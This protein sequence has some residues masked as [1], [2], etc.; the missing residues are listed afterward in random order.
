MK[1]SKGALNLRSN[2]FDM[3]LKLASTVL[4]TWSSY[5]INAQFINI[6]TIDKNL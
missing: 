3:K 1:S 6:F 2:S 4:V 5:N